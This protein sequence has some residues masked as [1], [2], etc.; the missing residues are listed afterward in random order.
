[1]A[2]ETRLPTS[3]DGQGSRM[4]WM[5]VTQIAVVD[6]HIGALCDALLIT[7]LRCCSEL[8]HES[9]ATRRNSPLTQS[10]CA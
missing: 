2:Q 7:R 5:R 4:P 9:V 1:V 8:P 3:A 6:P 10:G